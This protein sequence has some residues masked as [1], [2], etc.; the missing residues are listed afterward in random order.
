MRNRRL[1]ICLFVVTVYRVVAAVCDCVCCLLRQMKGTMKPTDQDGYITVMTPDES[2][3]VLVKH[4]LPVRQSVLVNDVCKLYVTS[5][6]MP[7]SYVHVVVFIIIV[8]NI[9][10][11]IP[12]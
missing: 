2:C 6:Q 7:H 8:I 3:D 5:P 11:R 4:S 10:I 1:V 12:K 9:I